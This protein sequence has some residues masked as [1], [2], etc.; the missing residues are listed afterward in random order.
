MVFFAKCYG[1]C[2][3][4][5]C[6][7]SVAT[8]AVAFGIYNSA[9]NSDVAGNVAVTCSAVAV[10]FNVAYVIKLSAGGAAS[11][12]P[13]TLANGGYTLQYNLYTNAARTHIWGDGTSS[14]NTVSDAYTALVLLQLKNYAVYG[15]LPASQNGAAGTY[16][17][18]ITVTV[19]Y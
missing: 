18:S 11:F 12:S 6:S 9:S 5:G 16:N 8:T 13:R 4:I 1:T 19:E 15:R 3:G 17:D 14:T 2:S 7:C 10:G